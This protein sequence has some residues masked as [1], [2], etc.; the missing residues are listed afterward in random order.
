MS[1]LDILNICKI[2]GDE[3]NLGS[4][5]KTHDGQTR[6]VEDPS[7]SEWLTEKSFLYTPVKQNHFPPLKWFLFARKKISVHI[8]FAVVFHKLFS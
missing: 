8:H 4:D 2:P 7:L 6:M 1:L 3:S 5:V